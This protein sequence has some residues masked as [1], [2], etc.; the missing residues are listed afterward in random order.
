VT[1]LP[2]L[3][4]AF[5]AA[6]EKLKGPNEHGAYTFLCP[7]HEDRAPS[8]AAWPGKDGRLMFGCY[9]RCPKPA[10]LAALGLGWADTF[11]PG[12]DRARGKAVAVERWHEYLG[13]A[14]ELLY[15]KGIVRHE[16]GSKH[17]FYQRWDRA[18]GAWVR[19]LGDA[20]RV[21]YRL[22][23]LLSS[24]PRLVLIVE[25]ERKADVLAELGFVATTAGGASDWLAGFGAYFAARPACIF[26]DHNEAGY[27]YAR[28]VAGSLLVAGCPCVRLF[29]WPELT[30]EGWDVGDDVGACRKAGDGVEELAERVREYVRG[31]ACWRVA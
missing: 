13:G 2:S 21:L 14:G 15:R 9:R 22:P 18:K 3:Y 17:G 20:G 26:P 31:S 28:A 29:R 4:P 5:F 27:A 7:A 19:G 12:E 30:P 11:P 10:I 16:D 24:A 25:G 8:G 23:E 6:L 1:D